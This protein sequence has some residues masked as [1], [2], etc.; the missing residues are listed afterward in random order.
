MM[1]YEQEVIDA[2]M[3]L[4]VADVAEAIFALDSD[5]DGPPRRRVYDALKAGRL[6][7]GMEERGEMMWLRIMLDGR[8]FAHVALADI[9]PELLPESAEF[10]EIVAK[11]DD[12]AQA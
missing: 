5:Q 10:E 9:A 2:A 8:E 7:Y 1:Q 6:R 12:D 4:R 11:F 3:W